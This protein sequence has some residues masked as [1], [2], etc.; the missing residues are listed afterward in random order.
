M[1]QE[2]E[3]CPFC[4]SDPEIRGTS[5]C[6]SNEYCPANGGSLQI[7]KDIEAGMRWWNRRA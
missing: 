1:N 7:P 2:L 5:V 6:C 4:G 3:P